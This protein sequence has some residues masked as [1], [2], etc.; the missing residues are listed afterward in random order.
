MLYYG[1]LF[2]DTIIMK[3]SCDHVISDCIYTQM[4]MF[5]SLCVVYLS[6][7]LYDMLSF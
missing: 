5:T 3:F 2:L 7:I 6:V 4:C 1:S